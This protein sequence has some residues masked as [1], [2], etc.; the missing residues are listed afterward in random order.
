MAAN[1]LKRTD[2]RQQLA[3]DIESDR[4]RWYHWVKP[5]ACNVARGHRA[6]TAEV[7]AFRAN[8][9]AEIE[10]LD[11]AASSY[12]S[13][14]LTEAGRQWAGL[15]EKKPFCGGCSDEALGPKWG[16][17]S[18]RRPHS[19]GLDHAAVGGATQSPSKDSSDLGGDAA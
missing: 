3:E 14:R 16:D 6:V 17:E 2:K 10:P 7:E 18:F 13:V 9:F 1:E 8:G 4:V 15:P 11:P 19:C 12:S 5:W